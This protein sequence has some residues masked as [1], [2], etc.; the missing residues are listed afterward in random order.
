[1]VPADKRASFNNR[2]ANEI[3]IIH[4]TKEV[5]ISTKVLSPISQKDEVDEK[6]NTADGKAPEPVSDYNDQ[7]NEAKKRPRAQ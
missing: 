3:M 5:F 4:G 7:N 2:S 1:M 6:D